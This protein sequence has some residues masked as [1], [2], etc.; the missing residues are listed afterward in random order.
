MSFVKCRWLEKNYELVE[1]YEKKENT[2]VQ[3]RL[4]NTG[5]GETIVGEFD[6]C[7]DYFDYWLCINICIT[8]FVYVYILGS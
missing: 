2:R 7:D 4:M 5:F 8:V 3:N 1:I 6:Y